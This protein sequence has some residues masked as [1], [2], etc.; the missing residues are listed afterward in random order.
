MKKLK[1]LDN[2][3]GVFYFLNK[4][5]AFIIPIAAI[6]IICIVY[7]S[8]F[9]YEGKNYTGIGLW[10]IVF[11]LFRYAIYIA[12]IYC[13]FLFRK[14]IKLFLELDFFN[15]TI[16]ELFNKIGKY[17]ITIGLAIILVSLIPINYE[18]TTPNEGGFS[19]T[20][21]YKVLFEFKFAWIAI[22][23]F[24]QVLSEIFNGANK[25]KQENDLTI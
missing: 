1:I 23:L 2:I 24:F 6:V 18:Y 10:L 22:G 12:L 11:C 16:V 14:I 17:L 19:I 3:T 8:G 13:L 20:K 4:C 25:L 7:N 21:E 15:H 9:D 5:V